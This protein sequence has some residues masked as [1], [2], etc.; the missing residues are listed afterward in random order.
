MTDEPFAI[1]IVVEWPALTPQRYEWDEGTDRVVPV[2]REE[3]LR[4]P[5]HYGCVPR[6]LTAADGELLDVLLL[7]NDRPYRPGEHV[8]ARLIGVLRRSDGD[9]KLVVV[10]PRRSAL[11]DIAQVEEERRAAM[12]RWFQRRH[13]LLRWD[14]PEAARAVLEDARRVWLLRAG[15]NEQPWPGSNTSTDSPCCGRLSS[16]R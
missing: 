2:E 13:V 10:D 4:P 3:K 12:W 11:T 15:R 16:W 5:E 14:G 1:D 9:N 6:A 8:A 7:R